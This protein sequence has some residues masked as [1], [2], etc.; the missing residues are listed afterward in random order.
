MT[1]REV[2]L[3][4]LN[5]VERQNAWANVALK[6]E[7]R[8]SR[9]DLRDAALATRLTFGVLQHQMLLDF[10]LSQFS[11]GKLNKMESR[12]RNI[13]RLG[14][15]QMLFLTRVP[16]SAAV[17]E[18]VELTRK[19]SKNPRAAGMVNAILRNLARNLNNLPLLDQS[20]PMAYLSLRTSHPLWLVQEL[21][22]EIPDPAELE[23]LLE[24][25]NRP[26]STMVQVNAC[27]C[28]V[29]EAMAALN[30]DGAAAQTH[31]WLA[32]CLILTDTGDLENL[33]AFHEGLIYVQD[34]AARLA[35]LAAGPLPGQRALD[36]C[37][38]PG[39]KTFA[40]AIAME[41]RGEVVS[42]DV[43]AHKKKLIEA[44]AD[45]LGLTC[46]T[47]GVADARK[48]K[49]AW[50]ESFDLV[51]ADVPCSGLGVIRKKPDLR[52][53]SPE[54]LVTLPALQGEILKTVAGYVKPGG[55][56]LYATCTLRR[57]ENGEVVDA[58]LADRPDFQWEAFSLPGGLEGGGGGS[59][60]LW[61]HQTGTD[62]FYIAKLRRSL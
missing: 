48:E 32:G 49:E 20:D 33:T 40:A 46:V 39:G 55:V 61:P 58:F 24:C 4:T 7:L 3:L 50:R 56:L 17:N 6:R 26:V 44:G 15:Y 54:E 41:N 62:G 19:H 28:T 53:K 9:L 45:R 34:P 11:T 12:V 23:A 60:T 5:G 8:R 18:S 1:A 37:A 38:A 14:L 35:V 52:Y 51:I 22:R 57:A 13:L 25:H 47:P 43:H 16:V 36:C 27:R 2:A 29:E 21:A 31:P 59:V 30:R 42:C 10:Y